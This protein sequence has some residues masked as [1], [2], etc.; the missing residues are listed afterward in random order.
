MSTTIPIWWNGRRTRVP[1]YPPLGEDTYADVCVV[2]LGLA[3]VTTA[4]LLA[5]EGKTVVGIDDG[6]I[7]GGETGRTT[8]HITAVLDDRYYALERLH[9]LHAA[10]LAAESHVAAIDKIEAIASAE[11]IQCEFERVDGYLS[12]PADILDRELAACHRAGLTNVERIGD[13]LKFPRQAQFDPVEYVETL[14]RAVVRDGGRLFGGTHAVEMTGGTTGRVVT[15]KGHTITAGAVV[16]A[17]GSPVNDVVTMHT[18]QA[19]YRTYVIAMP[20]TEPIEPALY[21]DSE[22]PYHYARTRGNMLIV[23]GGDHKTGQADDAAER[24]AAIEQW[25]RAK[26]PGTGPVQYRWSGQIL[27]PVD[28]LA[29]IGANPGVVPNIY[30]AT[31]DSGNGM[32]YGTIAGMLLTDLIACRDN[33]WTKL[34]DP[35]RLTVKSGVEY[36]RE[37]LNVAGQ[38]ARWITPGQV[39]TVAHIAKGEG[40]VIRRGIT[41]IAAYR[42]E[43]GKMHE[44][45]AVC[46]HLFCI[47][48][49]NSTEKTWDCPCHGSRFDPYGKVIN[50]PAV[51]HLEP[52]S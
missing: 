14:A 9:G 34:Y 52:L 6:G 10:R 26:F 23:G 41:K 50:G 12:G 32:T 25:A 43:Q 1:W 22:T 42:D 5:R 38:Y 3:G 48:D 49:W 40:A 19:A 28:G 33:P 31:G 2:G 36:A 37:N 39:A 51:T 46:P 4:Y 18:K 30:V 47:V 35:A 44:C 27:E 24:Y 21:W 29:F 7:A 11:D 45:S 13:R 17:T 16:V 15:D 8:A 20:T